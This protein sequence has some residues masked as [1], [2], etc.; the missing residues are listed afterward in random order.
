MPCSADFIGVPDW[1][2]LEA[3]ARLFPQIDP[4]DFMFMGTTHNDTAPVYAYKHSDT[5]RYLH[6]DAAGHAYRHTGRVNSPTNP[7]TPLPSPLPE[8]ERVLS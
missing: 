2:S 1:R 8:I 3:F 5:R 7:L 4:R 6:L